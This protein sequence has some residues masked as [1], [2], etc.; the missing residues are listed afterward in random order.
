M[1]ETNKELL[2]DNPLM[3]REGLPRFADVK[4]EH[5][6]PAIDAVLKEAEETL[7]KIE[8]NVIPTWDGL[9]KPLEEMDIPFDYS[10]S[11]INHLYS[12][13]T[14]DDLREAYNKVLP[15]M[16]A[17]GLRAAQSKPIYNGLKALRDSNEFNDLNDAQKRIIDDK[18]KSATHS[19]VGLEGEAKKRF[20]EIADRGSKISTDFSNHVLD[21]T[22]AF[23]LIITDKKDT[24]G[25]PANLKGLASQSYVNAKAKDSEADPENGPWRITLD[26]PSY[27]PFMKHS[28][29]RDMRHDVFHAMTTKASTGELDNNP[30]VIE[31]L[32]LRKEEAEILGFKTF[33]ELSLDSKMAPNVEAIEKMTQELETSAKPF[34][35][36][37]HEELKKAAADAGVVEPLKHW[38]MAYWSE[39]LREKTFNYTDEEIR[40]YFPLVNVLEGLFG[41]ANRLFGIKIEKSNEKVSKWHEDVQYFNVNDE[42]GEKIANF[43]LD[44]YSRPS[45]KRGGAWMNECFGRRIINGKV[46]LPVIYL[47]CNMTPP[48]D[49]KPSLMS[50]GEVSTLFHEF[51][52]GLQGMLTKINEADAAGVNGIEWDAVE[53]ASQFMENWCYHKKTLLGMAKHYKTGETLPE[54]LFNKI[55]AAKNFRSGTMMLRQL[56]LGKIDMYLHH[57]FDPNGSETPREVAM[58]IAKETN[59]YEPYEHSQFL[60]NFSHIFA[61]GYCAGYYSYKWAEVLSADAFG[62]FEEVG[63]DNEEEVKK[64]G[65]KY[66]N[67]ILALGGSKPPAEV[68]KMFRGRDANTEA[69]LRH[70]GLK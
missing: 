65:T 10:W 64:L 70:S 12:V 51:G 41:L 18:L 25:W 61:G 59:V 29:N 11:V 35:E 3:A 26:Y 54:D 9:L 60:C 4:P 22:K 8:S 5:F 57:N 58:R 49:G 56:E 17:F 23:E 13:K 14:S 48:S 63:L 45:E 36:K 27:V 44:P 6:E 47:V 68:Y 50:F 67:T 53:L 55:K 21:A 15:K 39:R 2:N 62:A 37:E 28:R 66:R 33:A 32:K 40:P 52:H 43:F 7:Q 38:D 46:R 24:E 19:G 34:A 1:N 42:N 20:N 31:R 16:V 69:L 30:L